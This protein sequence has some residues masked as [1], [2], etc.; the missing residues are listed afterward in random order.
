MSNHRRGPVIGGLALLV[1]AELACGRQPLANTQPSADAL[2][3]AVLAA[4]AEQ[5]DARLQALA[6]TEDEFRRDVWP[7]LPVARPERNLPFSYVWGDL[8]Q[9]SGSRRRVMLAAHR[10]RVYQL[11]HVSFSGGIT[12]YSGF[13]VHRDAV[14]EVQ[15]SAGAQHQLRLFGSALEK[16]GAWKI[17]SFNVD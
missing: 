16:D 4:L 7:S 3:R 6:L 11:R 8:R 5:D 14:L 13:R 12:E 9:K 1:L 17:F 2:G 10:G 15:D